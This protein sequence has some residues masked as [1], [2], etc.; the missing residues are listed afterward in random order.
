MCT[1]SSFFYNVIKNNVQI[2]K[3]ECTSET[4][5]INEKKNI[6]SLLIKEFGSYFGYE[7]FSCE[8]IRDWYVGKPY[9]SR[10][11]CF[12][13]FSNI[14]Y[15]AVWDSDENNR[16]IRL[17]LWETSDTKKL[18]DITYKNIIKK[19]LVGS[20]YKS[21]DIAI[22]FIKNNLSKIG[23]LLCLFEEIIPITDIRCILINNF[24]NTSITDLLVNLYIEKNSPYN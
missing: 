19:K 20:L 6:D 13:I 17:N 12:P 2:I 16:K 10:W 21:N 24:I 15:L 9:F 8:K 7:N 11:N 23:E 22:K 14:Q 4:I 5:S 3:S 18:C 1:L